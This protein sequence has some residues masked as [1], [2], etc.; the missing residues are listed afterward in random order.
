MEE[1]AIDR[2]QIMD[3]PLIL[4][5]EAEIIAAQVNRRCDGDRIVVIIPAGRKG[6]ARSIARDGA[7]GHGRSLLA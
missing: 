3:R 7:R 2:A 4:D 1:N 6:Y 5:I